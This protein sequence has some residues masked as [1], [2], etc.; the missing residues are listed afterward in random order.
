MGAITKLPEIRERSVVRSS[1]MASAKYSCSGSFDKFANGR[2]T[3]D[4][5]DDATLTGARTGETVAARF[6]T[7]AAVGSLKG[8]VH[9]TALPSAIS[10]SITASIR[11]RRRPDP[12]YGR[13]GRACA[14]RS[15]VNATAAPLMP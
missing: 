5:G 15:G 11:A 10:A 3:T 13:P 1:V 8:R 4:N 12:W 14:A 9:Q 6:R 2:T 7:D